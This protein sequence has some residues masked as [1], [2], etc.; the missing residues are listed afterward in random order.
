MT[1][2]TLRRVVA[3]TEEGEG[4]VYGPVGSL[5]RLVF[6]G[7]ELEGEDGRSEGDRVWR[8]TEAPVG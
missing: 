7:I 2:P 3:G 8:L 1:F 6:L 5:I 4:M